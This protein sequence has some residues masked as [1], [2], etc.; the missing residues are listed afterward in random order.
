MSKVPLCEKG[1]K[2]EWS[3]DT[4]FVGNQELQ[5]ENIHRLEI[6]YITF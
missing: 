1:M 3:E 6:L 4:N 5:Y 2:N